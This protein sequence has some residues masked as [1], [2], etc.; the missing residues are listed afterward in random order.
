MRSFVLM[1]FLLLAQN[2]AASSVLLTEPSKMRC[3]VEEDPA[4][5]RCNIV[6]EGVRVFNGREETPAQAN[7]DCV[8]CRN[9]KA[10]A[11]K[12]DLN[13]IMSRDLNWDHPDFLTL[14]AEEILNRVWR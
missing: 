13:I 3:Q 14:T 4:F 1:A 9:V 8:I 6:Y 2:A 12:N 10:H 5:W 7:A 11:D